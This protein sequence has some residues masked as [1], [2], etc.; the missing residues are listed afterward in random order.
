MYY[1]VEN[2]LVLAGLGAR[3]DALP[4]YVFSISRYFLK[5]LYKEPV[6]AWRHQ[7]RFFN[8]L[9]SW[10]RSSPGCPVTQRAQTDQKLGANGQRRIPLL[11]GNALQEQVFCLYAQHLQHTMLRLTGM[12]KGSA[13]APLCYSYLPLAYGPLRILYQMQ[14]RIKLSLW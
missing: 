13:R 3:Q 8:R 12:G 9:R 11:E 1:T 7:S 2:N 14:D 6:H 10:L 4:L 5:S